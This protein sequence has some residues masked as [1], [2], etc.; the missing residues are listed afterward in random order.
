MTAKKEVPTREGVQL[1]PRETQVL[2]LIAAGLSNAQIAHHLDRTVDTPKVHAKAIYEKLGKTNRA[3]AVHEAHVRG[4]IDE[5][6]V[7]EYR[8]LRETLPGGDSPDKD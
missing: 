2:H 4:L 6:L 5:D 1:T 7:A 3:G 8:P